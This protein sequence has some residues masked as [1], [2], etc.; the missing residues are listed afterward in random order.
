M[1]KLVLLILFIPLFSFAQGISLGSSKS[2]TVKEISSDSRL[3]YDRAYMNYSDKYV[4]A[5]TS[6]NQIVML[7]EI[8][9]GKVVKESLINYNISEERWARIA[10]GL[11]KDGWV[12]FSTTNEG[13][14]YA[15]RYNKGNKKLFLAYSPDDNVLGIITTM[16]NY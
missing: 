7:Y 3:E 15:N 9:S 11:E 14:N 8:S 16:G 5:V 2:S 6:N 4:R 1:K 12:K 13:G 10:I